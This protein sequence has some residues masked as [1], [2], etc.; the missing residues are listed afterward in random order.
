M[1]SKSAVSDI[2]VESLILATQDAL[3]PSTQA[4][5]SM[6]EFK[7]S[8]TY[9]TRPVAPKMALQMAGVE[10]VLAAFAPVTAPLAASA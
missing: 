7:T 2:Y 5:G 4:T 1:V 10:R 8:K 6:G 3:C 9:H